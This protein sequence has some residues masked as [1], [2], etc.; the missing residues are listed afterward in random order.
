MRAGTMVSASGSN[1]ADLRDSSPAEDGFLFLLI[2]LNAEKD[3]ASSAD[4]DLSETMPFSHK[5]TGL[6]MPVFQSMAPASLVL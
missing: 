1:S 6:L 3:S 2:L 4:A 5:E